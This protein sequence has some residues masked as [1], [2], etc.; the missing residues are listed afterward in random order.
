MPTYREED[1]EAG[2]REAPNALH[3]LEVPAARLV[4]LEQERERLAARVG[5]AVCD[6]ERRVHQEYGSVEVGHRG[7]R[8]RRV[9]FPIIGQA[10]RVGVRV[11]HHLDGL[12]DGKEKH[13]DEADVG[14]EEHKVR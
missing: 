2:E 13:R 6:D 9:P 3:A 7:R 8:R 14:V 11:A 4:R 12:E 10:L 1:Q 5:G